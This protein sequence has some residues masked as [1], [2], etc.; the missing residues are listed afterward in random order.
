MNY[1]A[2]DK[3]AY[4]PTSRFGAL[5]V[6]CTFS[7]R[8]LGF[9]SFVFCNCVKLLKFMGLMVVS[10]PSVCE[11]IFMCLV[12]ANNEK[13]TMLISESWRCLLRQIIVY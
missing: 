3:L 5:P 8:D 13:E 11:A 12:L 10:F 1:L 4:Q 2:L 9:K 7:H 6:N